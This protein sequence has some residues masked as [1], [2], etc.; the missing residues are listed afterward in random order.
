MSQVRNKSVSS[1][2]FVNVY[3]PMALAGHSAKEI[4]AK[5]YGVDVKDVTKAQIAN[6]TQKSTAMR[7]AAVAKGKSPNLVPTLKRG[8]AEGSGNTDF[9]SVL[10]SLNPQDE[11]ETPPDGE[12]ETPPTGETETQVS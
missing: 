5:L 3:V 1:V 4:A 7:K 9:L 2:D 6:V 10:E 8:R 11:T 12:T